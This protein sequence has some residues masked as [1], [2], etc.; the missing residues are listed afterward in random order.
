[1]SVIQLQLELHKI[2]YC[3]MQGDHASCMLGIAN[4]PGVA[5]ERS[6]FVGKGLG[7]AQLFET[8][9]EGLGR[10]WEL[11]CDTW[12]EIRRISGC[13]RCALTTDAAPRRYTAAVTAQPLSWLHPETV[14][15]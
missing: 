4:H 12:E 15:G 5:F 9:G 14:A 8:F 11:Q 10:A 7:S 2:D 3:L 13:I 1:M 6:I